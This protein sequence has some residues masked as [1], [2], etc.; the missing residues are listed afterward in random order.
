MPNNFRYWYILLRAWKLLR[1][2]NPTITL[3]YQIP[4]QV[5]PW[6]IKEKQSKGNGNKEQEGA[7]FGSQ[8]GAPLRN[9]GQQCFAQDWKMGKY[10]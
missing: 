1:A 3:A 8:I 6:D 5:S 10:L 2:N 4:N 7:V 9:N